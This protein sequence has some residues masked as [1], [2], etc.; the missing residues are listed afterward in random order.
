[1]KYL[2][3]KNRLSK[4]ILPIMLELRNERPW[5]EPFVGGAN[6]ID[7]IKGGI[8]I[9]NDKNEYVISLLKALQNDWIPPK[10]VSEEFYNEV[11]QN[12]ENYSK[13]LVGY[14]GTQ[15]TFGNIWFGSYRRDNTGKRKYD[16][17]AYNNVMNQKPNL[18][19]ILFL[20]LDYKN[21]DIPKNSIIYCDPPYKGSR[22]YIGDNKINHT[23]FWDWCREKSKSN[24][25]FISEYE[26]PE[27]FTCIWSKEVIVSGNNIHKGKL[28]NIEKL[29]TIN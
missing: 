3:S 12:K 20:N 27:D 16:L 15:L 5:V 17:E 26:A 8:K 4:H 24:T 9:G 23:E 21:I 14:F 13:E 28:K 19:E 10:E 6:I 1:M 2:G 7:K 11:K 29:F 25:V 22:P 18:K